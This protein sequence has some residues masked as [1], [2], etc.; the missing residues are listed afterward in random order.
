MYFQLNQPIK[1]ILILIFFQSSATPKSK[2]KALSDNAF[3]SE[4]IG[5]YFT[6]SDCLCT[7]QCFHSF[8]SFH[9]PWA[10]DLLSKGA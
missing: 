10:F 1:N 2:A 9:T 5:S 7:K 8:T 3:M 6:A 4:K